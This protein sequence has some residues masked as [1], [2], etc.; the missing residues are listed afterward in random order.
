MLAMPTI[1]ITTLTS[2]YMLSILCTLDLQLFHYSQESNVSIPLVRYVTFRSQI[3]HTVLYVEN[4]QQACD[5]SWVHV[6]LAI[7]VHNE[8]QLGIVCKHVK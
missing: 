6:Y 2:C 8:Q 5:I 7:H 4:V 3:V 1:L